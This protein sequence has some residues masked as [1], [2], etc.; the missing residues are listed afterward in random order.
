MGLHPSKLRPTAHKCPPCGRAAGSCIVSLP[1]SAQAQ[2]RRTAAAGKEPTTGSGSRFWRRNQR[3]CLASVRP[4]LS[5][6]APALLFSAPYCFAV[7][8]SPLHTGAI[9][10]PI[11][12]GWWANAIFLH[13]GSHP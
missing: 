8:S 4:S 10:I 2:A 5:F 13:T 7:P 6:S 11:P 9:A 12:V 1:L 3:R